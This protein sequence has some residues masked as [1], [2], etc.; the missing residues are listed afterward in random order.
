MPLLERLWQPSYAFGRMAVSV[1]D[2]AVLAA[3][4]VKTAWIRERASQGDVTPTVAMRRHLMDTRMP[5]E[6]MWVWIAR[7]TGRANFDANICQLQTTHRDDPWDTE[8]RRHI[9]VCTLTLRG[10]SILIRTDAGGGVPEMRPP[11]DRWR[12]FWP[13]ARAVQWSTARP[14]ADGDVQDVA[15]WHDWVRHPDVP[16]F[17]RAPDYTATTRL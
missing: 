17:N 11:D 14:V 7:H 6:L 8:R 4:A 12:R 1:G 5:G 2:A 13:T 9:L 3:W 10:L 16:I 15:T